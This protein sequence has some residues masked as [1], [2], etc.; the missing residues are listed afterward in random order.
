MPGNK[1]VKIVLSE[2][3][4]DRTVEAAAHHDQTVSEF[5][6]SAI[7]AQFHE[8]DSRSQSADHALS[9]I[10]AIA[11]GPTGAPSPAQDTLPFEPKGAE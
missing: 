2:Q 11:S 3:M 10:R 7:R 4:W 5:I 1:T 6:R 9:L 8:Q